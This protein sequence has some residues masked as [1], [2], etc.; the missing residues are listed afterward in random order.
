MSGREPRTLMLV[1]DRADAPLRGAVEQGRRPSPEYLYL[2]R[3]H[4]VALLDW[5]SLPGGGYARSARLSI[6]HA[7]HAARRLKGFDVVFSDGEHVGV[8]LALAMQALGSSVPHVM[9]GHH[10]TTPAKRPFFRLL[11]SHRG[12]SRILVHSSRQLELAT[13]R[14]G[15]SCDKLA[16]VPYGADTDFWSPRNESECPLVVS[17][18]REHRDYATLAR[19]CEVLHVDVFIAA[20]SL[21]SPG[22][23]Q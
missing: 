5:S 19:A 12:I 22:A 16:L 9:L 3:E 15:I 10:L 7:M 14:L 20:G 18:G 11:P 2:E 1:S 23:H 6:R 21:H 8:P 13:S 17:A 4:N